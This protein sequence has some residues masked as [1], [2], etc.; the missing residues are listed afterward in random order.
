MEAEPAK[1]RS[2]RPF[3]QPLE[4]GAV[5]FMLAG[6]VHLLLPVSGR[7]RVDDS[8]W[9]WLDAYRVGHPSEVGWLAYL[10]IGLAGASVLG[11]I[12]GASH[13]FALRLFGRDWMKRPI[14]WL[15]VAAAFAIGIW[16]PLFLHWSPRVWITPN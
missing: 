2:A 10:A 13:G 12:V 3:V 16:L 15:F 4:T 6:L 5:A 7:V 14:G 1:D 9:S 8:G 11:L